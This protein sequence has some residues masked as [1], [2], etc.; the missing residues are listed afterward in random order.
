MFVIGYV[1]ANH[2]LWIL[3]DQL[4]KDTKA[5]LQSLKTGFIQ[6][7][8]KPRL[9]IHDNFNVF[10]HH[11]EKEG[12][13]NFIQQIITNF[14]QMLKANYKLPAIILILLDNSKLD[15]PPFATTALPRLIKWLLAEIDFMIKTR[16]GQLPKRCT[17]PVEPAVYLLKFLPR[18]NHAE[19]ADLFKS[20][21]RKVNNIIPELV[22]EFQFGFIN[23]YEI[24]TTTAL[25]F[26]S[27]G[28]K[29]TQ[30]GIVQFWASISKTIQSII[31]EKRGKIKPI[32]R[33]NTSQTDSVKGLK[34]FAKIKQEEED[35][36]K[37]GNV[38]ESGS[39]MSTQTNKSPY[40]N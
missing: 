27:T 14:A 11:E 20:V 33:S 31:E 16:L 30:A 9:F 25:F 35:A 21:R 19:N 13:Q 38:S 37:R 28:T 7:S 5:V 12:Q 3:G 1:P 39:R 4:L 36:G 26:N 17:T 22:N 24:N 18:T 34:S 8:A 10:T 32:L 2:Q 23:A 40:R 29:L 15:D 6:D